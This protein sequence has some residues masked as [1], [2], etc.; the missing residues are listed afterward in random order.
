MIN[1]DWYPLRYSN[2]EMTFIQVD[3]SNY[4]GGHEMIFERLENNDNHPTISVHYDSIEKLSFRRSVYIMHIAYGGSTLLSRMF[5]ECDGFVSLMEPIIHAMYPNDPKIPQLFTRGF[6]DNDVAVIK[7]LPKEMLH[8][9]CYNKRNPND[10]FV[11]LHQPLMDFILSCFRDET[12]LMHATNLAC[13]Y[14]NIDPTNLK[15]NEDKARILIRFWTLQMSKFKEVAHLDN[16]V[17]I[18]SI[19]LFDNPIEVMQTIHAH[20]G[21]SLTNDEISTINRK[22]IV[23]HSKTG[24]PYT[25][26][27]RIN[28]GLDTYKQHQSLID[29]LDIDSIQSRFNLT[30]K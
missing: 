15:S 17:C 30:V 20:I 11:L 22:W 7:T 13:N 1:A 10:V 27:D 26:E 2:N 19:D 24:T 21:T 12:R 23:N 4:T 29:Q 18:S 3:P 8:F 6:T 5:A 9:E 16:V 28:V 14:I 25:I